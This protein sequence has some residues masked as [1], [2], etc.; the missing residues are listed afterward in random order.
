MNITRRTFG[1]FAAGA[2]AGLIAAPGILRAATKVKLRYG[3]A[4]PPTHPGVTRIVEASKAIA[5]RSE[6]AIDLQVYPGSQLGGE[7]DMFA[8]VRGGALDLMSTSSVN[9]TIVPF[10][11]INAV[12]FAFPTYDHVW[13]AMDGDLG[14]FVRKAFFEAGLFVFPKMLDNGYRNITTGS[15]PILTPADLAG[16]KI[17]VPGNQL[18]VTL[19]Q[20]LGAAPTPL[21]FGELYAA[22]QTHIVDGQENPLALIQ[23]SKLYEVQKHVSMTGHIWDGHHIFCN[24]RR[25][26][27]IP[28]EAQTI[29]LEELSTAAV[30]ER[31]DIKALNEQARIDIEA[32][33]LTFHTVDKAPFRDV[34]AQA[35]FYAS[36]KEK[37]GAEAWG[38]LEKDVGTL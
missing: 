27:A 4:F 12:A 9:Q 10:A 31:A 5:A 29:L 19:F 11:A 14:D 15:K 2:A 7:S 18:W 34:L 33:G 16:M 3:T 28:A 26:S 23:S 17:R 21:N 24:N 32:T 1:T 38:L 8:Q 22:L 37:F 36:W 30:N 25:W 13:K 6:G 35:G 20:T